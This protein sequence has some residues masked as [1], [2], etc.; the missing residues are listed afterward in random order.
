MPPIWVAVPA[1]QCSPDPPRRA[2]AP[3]LPSL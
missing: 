2:G 1:V 3:R